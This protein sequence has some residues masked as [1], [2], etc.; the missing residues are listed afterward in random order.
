MTLAMPATAVS[1]TQSPGLMP[2]LRRLLG[3]DRQGAHAETGSN[4]MSAF[5]IRV[6]GAACIYLSQAVLARWLGS[7]EF[8]SYIYAWTWV[9]LI[10]DTVHLG[11]GHVAQRFIPR[12]Q[13]AGTPGHVLGFLRGSQ[14]IVLA[15]A[16]VVAGLAALAAQL[17]GRPDSLILQLAAA[18]IPAFALTVLFDGIARCYNWI[19][20]ALLPAYVVRPLL[21]TALVVAFHLA[22]R[23]MDALAA[24]LA[25]L[26]VCWIVALV[27]GVVTR[28]RLAR[29]MAAAPR[30]YEIGIWMGASLPTSFMWIFYMLLTS[31]DVIVLQYFHPGEEVAHYYAAA[32][33][34]AIVSFVNFAVGAAAGHRF[35]Q[36]HAAGDGHGLQALAQQCVRWT[37]SGSFAATL[38]ILALGWPFLWLFGADFVVAYPMMFILAVGTL[39]RAS[40]GPAERLLS[41]SGHQNAC[42]MIYAAAFAFNLALC[43]M[44]AGP[45]GGFGVSLAMSAAALLE[46]VLM[47]AA[48]RRYL[49]ITPFIFQRR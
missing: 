35:A 8:G 17:S 39:A 2:L 26:A 9:I 30:R 47:L 14:I 19:G 20:L 3:R 25:T 12:Y 42:A 21:L 45:F 44:L 36:F 41:M 1:L 32:K 46:S 37:F 48:S 13:E 38:V 29:Q 27:Q 18:A 40:I 24:M 10:G 34:L 23:H 15:S 31:T 28:L 5:L 6:V 7:S 22:G 43:F 16:T 11:L 33:T 49:G 4:A